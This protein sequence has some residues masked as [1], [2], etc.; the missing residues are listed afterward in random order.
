MVW[1]KSDLLT[2]DIRTMPDIAAQAGISVSAVTG[3]GLEDL[4]AA[5][6]GILGVT[7]PTEVTLPPE[8]GK[9]RAWLYQQGAVIEERMADD[10]RVA[11]TLRADDE[12]LRRLR[13]VPSVLVSPG[14]LQGEDGVPRISPLPN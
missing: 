10:G 6:A 11:M 8:D 1:N 7:E 2:S 9:T 3:D 13:S 5:I 14:L 4:E 12:L